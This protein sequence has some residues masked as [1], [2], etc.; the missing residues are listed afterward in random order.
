MK[1]KLIRVLIHIAAWLVFLAFPII[2]LP[3]PPQ[4]ALKE[5]G[6][7]FLIPFLFKSAVMIFIFYF[8]YYVL[9]PKYLFQKKYAMY[10]ALC[11][12]CTL[13][14][15]PGPFLRMGLMD[16]PEIPMIP[17]SQIRNSLF[18]LFENNLL[19]FFVVFFAS[20]GLALNTRWK[21][22]E[23]ER[24][25][26]QLSYLKTQINPHFLFNT[27]NSIYSVTI[28]KAPQGAEMVDKLSEMMRYTLKETQ[29][30]FVPLEKEINYIVNF[31]DLQKVRFDNSVK[32]SFAVE[33]NFFDKQIAPLLLIPFIENAFKH[34]V[35]SEQ[36]SDI[37]ITVSINENELNLNV[38][39][40]KVEVQNNEEEK[41]G[42]G[43]RNTQHRLEL[44]Y[45]GKHILN[46]RD[47]AT[48]F[49]VSLKIE[50]T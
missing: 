40:N 27:L 49:S 8:N 1:G 20:I 28:V 34:G 31:I 26:A 18:L 6:Y 45:P 11:I 21:Q 9:I 24:L 41:S 10:G 7:L 15:L 19:S 2:L 14:L 30:D 43:I 35:N 22:T 50:L 3:K 13:L 33:G 16:R 42:L 44:I 25:S 29:L 32:F 47:T 5:I 23:K 37:K 36:D 17:D 38:F 4:A 39:N 46:I 12:A 48:N